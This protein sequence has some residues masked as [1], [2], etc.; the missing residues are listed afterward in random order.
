MSLGIAY[1]CRSTHRGDHDHGIEK[2][3]I[4]GNI[5]RAAKTVNHVFQ[6]MSRQGLWIALLA[7]PVG[8]YTR[9]PLYPRLLTAPKTKRYEGLHHA[10]R[11]LLSDEKYAPTLEKIPSSFEPLFNSAI[12]ATSIR[13]ADTS[14]HGHDSFRYEWGTWVVEES[15]EY[16]M[17]QINLVRLKNGAYDTLLQNKSSSIRLRVAGGSDWDCFLHI[18]PQNTEWKGRWPTGSWAIVKSLSG[19]V[20]VASLSGPNRDGSYKTKTSKKLRGGG[21][22]SLGG[23]QSSAGENA[24]KYVGGPLRCYRGSYGKSALMEIVIRPPIGLEYL[25]EDIDILKDLDST[26]TIA[27]L[28][29]ETVEDTESPPASRATPHLGVKLGMEFEKVGGLDKQ[30]E[31]IARRVLASRANPA[32]ARRLG[33]SHVR[34]ILLSGPPGCGKT[35]LARELASMLGA[36]E[37]QIVNGPEILDKYIGEAEKKVRELFL[38]A[39]QEYKAAGDDSALHII[40]LDEMDAIARKRGTMTADTTGVRDSVVNQL[41]AKMDGVREASNILVVG[42]TNRPELLDPALLRPGRLEVQL[43]VELPDLEGTSNQR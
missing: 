19:M 21:D 11:Q 43:R 35:L 1:C 41:L 28:L 8:A 37:P 7:V 38:P 23:G 31:A 6:D 9:L 20:E 34:G 25:D 29:P 2:E 26:F 27:E 40:I 3:Y 16:L 22:G 17:Q 30:L 13:G 4:R 42:L 33:V 32:A 15:L 18:L 10:A 39:E 12:N 14:N 24:I 36:R 5:D